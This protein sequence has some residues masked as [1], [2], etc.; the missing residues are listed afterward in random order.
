MPYFND[1]IINKIPLYQINTKYQRK[2]IETRNKES[3]MPVPNSQKHY[4]NN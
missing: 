2:Q 1:R 3:V 4:H